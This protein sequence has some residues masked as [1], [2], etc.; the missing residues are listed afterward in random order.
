MTIDYIPHIALVSIC[1]LLLLDL[2]QSSKSAASPTAPY[3]FAYAIFLLYMVTTKW[4]A[5]W[6]I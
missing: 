2:T 5:G 3:R 6:P 1:H 4:G